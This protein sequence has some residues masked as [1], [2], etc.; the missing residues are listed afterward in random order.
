MRYFDNFNKGPTSEIC[1]NRKSKKKLKGCVWKSVKNRSISLANDQKTIAWSNCLSSEKQQAHE[2]KTRDKKTQNEICKTAG[3][4]GNVKI[5]AS[6]SLALKSEVGL[7]FSEF[8][9]TKRCLKPLGIHF[10]NEQK[11]REIREDILK[12]RFSSGYLENSDKSSENMENVDNK[13]IPIVYI[14]EFRIV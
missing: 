9:R 5:P 8:R 3:I 1:A 7:N 2:L 10:E 4:A 13:G 11:E 6:Y 14:P 12:N